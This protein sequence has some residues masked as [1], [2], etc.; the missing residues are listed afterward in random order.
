M[1][2]FPL[3]QPVQGGPM[4]PALSR[5]TIHYRAVAGSAM[6]HALLLLAVYEFSRAAPF[7]KVLEAIPV[8]IV[9]EAP[10]PPLP[11][12]PG[13]YTPAQGTKPG[14]G[15][16]ETAQ[17]PIAPPPAPAKVTLPKPAVAKPAMLQSPQPQHKMRLPD[18]MASTVTQAELQFP[19]P[20]KVAQMMEE[21]IADPEHS[22][23]RE[24]ASV[25]A[26]SPPPEAKVQQNIIAYAQ[27]IGARIAT[28]KHYPDGARKHAAHGTAVVSFSV[29][30][31]GRPNHIRI[32][33]SAGDRAL[34][35]EAL[36]TVRRAAP[37]AAPP[38]GAPNEY[39]VVL[40]FSV[41]G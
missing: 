36:E 22:S 4:F 13:G 12:Q 41:P 27:A 25:T 8:Q 24:Q 17:K 3:I 5:S 34:D 29:G 15:G 1:P 32:A 19:Q 33:R 6:V 37:F 10:K 26:P 31:S 30:P 18:S 39:S 14:A 20:D 28:M 40:S 11:K 21:V 2:D 23:T 7:H 38:A 35:A 9:M 16:A